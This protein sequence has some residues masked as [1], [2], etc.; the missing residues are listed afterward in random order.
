M[1]DLIIDSTDGL[2]DALGQ[3]REEFSKGRTITLSWRSEGSYTST[4]RASLHR[5]FEMLANTLNSGGFDMKV[6]FKEYGKAGMNAPWTKDSIKSVFYKPTLEA[7]TGKRSTEDMNTLEPSE[8]C[9]II[10][11]SLAERLG[12]TPPPWPTRLNI[13]EQ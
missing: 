10:G 6:W 12:I 1:P 7:M 8:I 13:G 9:T 5:W 11:A 2:L 4:Q 3:L